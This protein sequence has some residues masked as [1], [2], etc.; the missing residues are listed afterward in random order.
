[1]CVFLIV[2]ENNLHVA[3]ECIL[4]RGNLGLHDLILESSV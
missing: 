3:G 1:M 2:I 4:L